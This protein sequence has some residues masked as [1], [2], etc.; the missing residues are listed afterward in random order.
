MDWRAQ[1]NRT[2]LCAAGPDRRIASAAERALHAVCLRSVGPL[3]RHTLLVDASDAYPRDIIPEC[4]AKSS[5]SAERDQIGC[6][7]RLSRI[8]GA[9]RGTDL[10]RAQPGTPPKSLS[11]I[12]QTVS[13]RRPLRRCTPIS[14][15]YR[16]AAG[17]RTKSD[18]DAS[19]QG[20]R[21]FA[22]PASATGMDRRQFCHGSAERHR[23]GP[24]QRNC[25]ANIPRGIIV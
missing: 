23:L 1:R 18:V 20:R 16:A 13:H 6:W 5:W 14:F 7:A 9:T 11:A 24:E 3:H 21:P 12:V 15:Y 4:R 17:E 8:R 22:D 2:T 25:C 10:S 19:G